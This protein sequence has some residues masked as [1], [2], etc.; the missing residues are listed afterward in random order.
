MNKPEVTKKDK[1]TQLAEQV[2]ALS[3]DERAQLIRRIE[4]TDLSKY[5]GSEIRIDD[6]EGRDMFWP[7]ATVLYRDGREET[8]DI[9]KTVRENASSIGHPAILLAIRRWEHLVLYHHSL[10]GGGQYKTTKEDFYKLAKDHLQKIGEAL[11]VGAKERVIPKELTLLIRQILGSD[12]DYIYLRRVWKLL[13]RDD[14]KWKILNDETRRKRSPNNKLQILATELK[15]YPVV[16]FSHFLPNVLQLQ[17][18]MAERDALE[19]RLR[20][21]WQER[22]KVK[23]KI[24]DGSVIEL[25]PHSTIPALDNLSE[26]EI[27]LK[28][29][30][31][32]V[33]WIS[34]SDLMNLYGYQS[35]LE[36]QIIL[37]DLISKSNY[38]IPGRRSNSRERKLGA[39]MGISEVSSKPHSV[40]KTVD[41]GVRKIF[42][43]EKVEVDTPI[44]GMKKAKIDMII[45]F[46]K[47]E[48]GRKYLE[49]RPN[50][51]SFSTTFRAWSND[52]DQNTMKKYQSM[53]RG[54]I[55]SKK[56]K[57]DADKH[58]YGSVSLSPDWLEWQF[59]L[60]DF[61]NE[62]AF[63]DLED[64]LSLPTSSVR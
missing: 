22:D 62:Y 50:W 1:V 57:I 14:I 41:G 36:D 6:W 38:I 55:E 56:R 46:L 59:L 51:K 29:P 61:L 18:S 64:W 21:R 30:E 9:I 20:Y 7:R 26:Y 10:S 8:I 43:I 31:G 40:T 32:A 23:L 37:Q 3:P 24:P 47:T 45:D 27:L 35:M 49:I 52:M 2:Y 58:Q 5:L 44:E 54:K 48:K 39:L 15:Q 16:H 42:L 19:A 60:P 11:L 17:T 25:L 53:A 34:V 4:A 28:P 13:G 33:R 12:L 63:S